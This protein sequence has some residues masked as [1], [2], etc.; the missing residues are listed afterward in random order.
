MSSLAM[1]QSTLL[2]FLLGSS[3]S[4]N[5]HQINWVVPIAP[6]TL[7]I[8]KGESIIF[9]G[10]ATHNVHLSRG[11]SDW[12]VC[13]S[14]RGVTVGSIESNGSY[15][16]KMD[17]GGTF[18]YSCT[19]PNDACEKGQKIAITVVDGVRDGVFH[20]RILNDIL[21]FYSASATAL[22]FVGGILTG[23]AISLGLI[24]AWTGRG[25]ASTGVSRRA[26]SS[27]SIRCPKRA[28]R[29]SRGHKRN[30]KKK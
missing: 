16:T 27:C 8:F 9:V 20:E 25:P 14:D 5:P 15:E 4:A 12:D 3:M 23:S 6:Q 29:G 21:T 7:T 11:K 1:R 2:S 19:W 22:G 28:H 26:S 10:K 17:Q 30:G 13:D 24:W 18:Y